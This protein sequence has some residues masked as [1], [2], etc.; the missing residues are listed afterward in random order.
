MRIPSFSYLGAKYYLR[1]WIGRYFPEDVKTYCEPCGGRGNMFWYALSH[2]KAS[3]YIIGDI[4]TAPFF[5]LLQQLSY[6]DLMGLVGTTYP[7]RKE[8]EQLREQPDLPRSILLEPLITFS[9]GGY[10]AGYRNPG[11]KTKSISGHTTDILEAS[12]LLKAK[13]VT[14]VDTSWD[15]TIANLDE[16]D[17][18]YLDPPYRSASVRAYGTKFDYTLMIATLLRARFRWVL[19]EYREIGYVS[20]FGE[21][22]STREYQL[23]V[24]GA[25]DSRDRSNIECIWAN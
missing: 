20:A 2:L 25:G 7:T 19:S 6:N 16:N 13:N 14:I 22:L 4:K 8:F 11:P 21:P 3:N 12:R 9:G 24:S 17:F 23:K 5:R 1:N 18:V 15:E 10:V